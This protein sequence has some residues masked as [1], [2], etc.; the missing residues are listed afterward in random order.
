MGIH[1]VVVH[2]PDKKLRKGLESRLIPLITVGIH[3]SQ[4]IGR[5]VQPPLLGS[6][7]AGGSIPSSNQFAEPPSVKNTIVVEN[8]IVV[9]NN[10]VVLSIGKMKSNMIVSAMIY[11]QQGV[12]R[13]RKWGQ[14]AILLCAFLW[15][16]SGLFIKLVDWHPVVISGLRS[17][18][19][20]IFMLI[21]RFIFAPKIRPKSSKGPL[22]AAAISYALTMQTFVIANKLTAS[23]NVIMLQY[24]A[25]MWAALLGW[26]FIR[27]K[28]HW[29]HWG[30]M[31][32]VFGGLA[33][34]FKDGLAGN[35]FLGDSIAL[36]S[37]VLFGTQSVF[38]RMQKD[39]NPADAM[40]L[41]HIVSFAFSIPFIFLYPPT[42]EAS[43]LAAILYM[44]VIQIGCASL[45][46]SYGIKR[47]SAV[48][49]MLTAIIEPVLNPL[50][51]LL[52]TRERPSLSALIG[53]SVIIAAVAVS[54]LIAKKRERPERS[55]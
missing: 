44:G 29:E 7:A 10:T 47:V 24:S 15:S 34:F 35:S 26:I 39:G 31:V 40:L 28:P 33:L 12:V 46:F 14:S 30:A 21:I 52:I 16:T 38:L 2:P 20:G 36:F 19:A 27:E 51:V 22:W 41:S 45:L 48:Q 3:I 5:R 18:I 54:S 23:A 8:T 4:V 55:I 1:P 25:P 13:Q 32:C 11:K 49:A 42:L 37:G 53:G 6:H 50:W 43:N 17:L 9:K